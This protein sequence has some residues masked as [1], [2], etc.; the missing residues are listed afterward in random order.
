MQFNILIYKLAPP[1]GVIL[2]A[3]YKNISQATK[4]YILSPLFYNHEWLYKKGDEA[5]EIMNIRLNTGEKY[6]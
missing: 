4:D 2:E 6:E 5:L 1:D 3:P